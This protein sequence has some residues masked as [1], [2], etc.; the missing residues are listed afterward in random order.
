MVSFLEIYCGQIRDLGLPYVGK[1]SKMIDGC[2]DTL[3]R[4][5]ATTIWDDRIPR[6]GI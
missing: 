1:I 3:I 5:A 2:I 6:N 4:W